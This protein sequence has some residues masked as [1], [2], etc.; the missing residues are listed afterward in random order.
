MVILKSRGG[1]PVGVGRL[2]VRNG[3]VCA[4]TDDDSI[5]L[6]VTVK[7]IGAEGVEPSTCRLYG[8]CSAGL[9]YTPEARPVP[10][11]RSQ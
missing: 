11:G 5:S 3:P 9:S 6:P 4:A 2:Y 1:H 8:D 7:L 10:F